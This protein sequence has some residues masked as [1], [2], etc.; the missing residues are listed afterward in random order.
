M[1]QHLTPMFQYRHRRCKQ[2]T[3]DR[4]ASRPKKIGCLASCETSQ[5]V[6]ESGQVLKYLFDRS[7]RVLA[8]LRQRSSWPRQVIAVSYRLR[9][10]PIFFLISFI[11]KEQQGAVLP[12]D[13]ASPFPG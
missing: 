8:A 1:G 7:M 6:A 11:R 2:S 9:S 12:A 13:D 4:Q 10:R 5:D 3:L